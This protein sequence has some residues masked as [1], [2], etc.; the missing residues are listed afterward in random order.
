MTNPAGNKF[1]NSRVFS[2]RRATG[3][4]HCSEALRASVTSTSPRPTH[5]TAVIG[6][7]KGIAEFHLSHLQGDTPFADAVADVAKKIAFFQIHT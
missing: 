4:R 1:P 5:R 7:Y 3:I 2:T 6:L